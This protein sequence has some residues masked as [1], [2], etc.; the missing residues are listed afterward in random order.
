L[1][2]ILYQ[3]CN[4]YVYSQY[5]PRR[6]LESGHVREFVP[7]EMRILF[8]YA[9]LEVVEEFTRFIDRSY[10]THA[11]IRAMLETWNLPSELRGEQYFVAARK[12]TGHDLRGYPESIFS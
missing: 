1:A 4:P 8:A 10:E 9:G 3:V 11:S 7:C 12:T 6:S 5:P 2:N